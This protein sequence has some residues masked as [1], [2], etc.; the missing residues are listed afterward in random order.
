MRTILNELLNL[1]FP[2]LCLLCKKP[3][4][5]GEEHLCICCLSDLPRTHFPDTE[6][7]PAAQL[8]MGKVDI[9]RA[10]ALYFYEKESHIQQLIHALKYHDNKE[11]GFYLGRIATQ[12]FRNTK[13]FE[14]TD[15]LLPVPLHPQ[16]LRQRGYNQSEWIARGISSQLNI[17]I[18]TFTLQRREQTD[19]QTNKHVYERWENVQ[20]VF[21]VAN[22]DS[23]KGKHILLIDDVITTGSTIGACA[24]TLLTIPGVSI[25]MFAIAIATK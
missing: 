2:Q 3:L 18:D 7:N 23:L 16:K 13:L 19:T 11:L 10:S 6:S 17:P 25:S 4:I 20:D 21:F 9:S 24:E 22:T 5:K 12:E 14:A 1:F 8:F 15:L